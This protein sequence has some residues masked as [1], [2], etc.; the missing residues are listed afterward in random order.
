MNEGLEGSRSS[1]LKPNAKENQSGMILAVL[2]DDRK[3]RKKVNMMRGSNM[4]AL[5]FDEPQQSL[6][7]VIDR[8]TKHGLAAIG[9]HTFSSRSDREKFRIVLPS[10]APLG[11][12]EERIRWT[13]SVGQFLQEQP[14]LSCVDP[15]RLHYLPSNDVK[16]IQ[17]QGE[18]ALFVGE[19]TSVNAEA[20]WHVELAQKLIK[21]Q[22]RE[23]TDYRSER[24]QNKRSAEQYLFEVVYAGDEDRIRRYEMAK[25]VGWDMIEIV[26][27]YEGSEDLSFC[28]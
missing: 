17:G 19:P 15:T 28:A 12:R 3:G 21:K 1:D 14:D 5:G 6:D 25:R 10:N 11:G 18:G 26:Q 9:Y 27:E 23:W 22:R 2:E 13:K 4:L 7:Q 8:L 20:V 16:V 24:A